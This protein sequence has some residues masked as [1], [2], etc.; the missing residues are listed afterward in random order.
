M[1]RNFSRH[2]ELIIKKIG[3]LLLSSRIVDQMFCLKN[4]HFLFEKLDKLIFHKNVENFFHLFPGTSFENTL[5][6]D[7]TPPKGMFN[8]CFNVIFFDTF[9]GSNTNSN[10]LFGMV[11]PY[12]ESLYS[13]RMHVYK[14]VELHTFDTITNVLP[15]EPRYEKLDACCSIKCDETYCNK[16]KSKF[17]NKKK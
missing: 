7:D 2:L 9:C 17:V 10:Y 14:L 15:N 5:L 4:D 11:F 6:V 16:M 12:L 13:S 1:K 8:P 3:V